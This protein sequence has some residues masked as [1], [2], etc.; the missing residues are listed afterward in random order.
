MP[1]SR[2]CYPLAGGDYHFLK[3][4]YG[5]WAGFLLGWVNF[6]IIGPGSLA[7]MSIAL[8]SYL[9]SFVLV[10][11][12]QGSLLAITFILLFSLINYRGLRLSGTIQDIFTMGN[13]CI[14]VGIIAGGLLL[15]KGDW[16]HFASGTA[17]PASFIGLSS[18]A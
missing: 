8:V 17:S 4:A 15:G 11:G 18:S 6:W 2:E 13:I 12:E 7:A 10:A 5:R 16:S 3:A 9:K 1:N 14:L